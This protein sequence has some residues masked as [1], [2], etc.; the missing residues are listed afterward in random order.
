MKSFNKI[1]KDKLVNYQETPPQAV[2]D[3][4]RNQYPKRSFVEN[5][6][7]NKYYIIAG[8]ATVII[9]GALLLTNLTT[10]N[11][12]TKIS[13][14]ENKKIENNTSN[15]IPNPKI[16]N[17]TDNKS[18]TKN[19]ITNNPS[20]IEQPNKTLQIE[21]TNYFSCNDT[22]ICGTSLEFTNILEFEN[23]II[24]EE[25]ETSRKDAKTIISTDKSGKHT[26]YYRK[27]NNNK[28]IKDS[29]IITFNTIKEPTV[30]IKNHNLCYGQELLVNIYQNNNTTL[31]G[32]NKAIKLNENLYQINEL[33]TGNNIIEIIFIDE[34]DCSYTYTDE[35]YVNSKPDYN[36]NITP[37]FCS[38]T[39]GSINIIPNNFKLHSTELNNTLN[40]KTGIFNNLSAGIYFIKTE[41]A[42]S[43]YVHDTLLI[44][45]SLNISPYFRIEKDLIDNN[46]YT[47]RNYTKINNDGYEQN[48][49][50]EFIWKINGEDIGNNDNPEFTINGQGEYVIELIASINNNCI[51]Q[52]SETIYVSETNFRIPN[53]FTPNGDGIGDYFKIISEKEL[54]KYQI[55]IVNKLGE[56][57]FES[58]DFTDYWDGKTNGNDDASEGLYYYII[59]GEDMFGKRVEQ[60]GSLQLVRN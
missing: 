8:F 22:L 37:T 6:N 39:N 60:K 40:S 13:T 19:N 21:Y 47:V 45:D 51:A 15:Q 25:L 9:A 18:I 59:K 10:P 38:Q 7:Y 41:Y 49:D 32:N 43:C 17:K 48:S 27:E 34:N 28:L 12:N 54:R 3:N 20:E 53:I 35:I 11:K 5:I 55:Q 57:I 29:L 52:Y 42:P 31:F 14:K 2:L 26:I 46:K 58:T 36:I 24:P 33:Q 16:D 50:I 23:L 4:I 30:K 1:I 44:R 56:L